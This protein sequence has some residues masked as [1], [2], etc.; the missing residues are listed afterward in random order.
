MAKEQKQEQPPES[1]ADAPE[2]L[3]PPKSY[4]LQIT[5]VLAGL[6][7]FQMFVLLMLF[8]G[9]PKTEYRGGIDPVN[10][11]NIY[12][13]GT[14]PQDLLP[15]E[16]MVERLIKDNPFKFTQVR[17]GNTESFSLVMHVRVRKKEVSKF[18]N[19]FAECKNEI[20]SQI[21]VVLRES[22]S[23]ERSDPRSTAIKEKAKIVIN[24]V[25][26]TPFVLEVLVSDKSYEV[27]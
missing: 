26:R 19:R 15:P 5:L 22:I 24:E 9:K 11:P 20:V 7:L 17:D 10:A 27:N 2:A 21:E 8:P 12:G 3:G 18:D 14:A 6:L 1:A 23:E 4:R 16:M 25:L 13:M